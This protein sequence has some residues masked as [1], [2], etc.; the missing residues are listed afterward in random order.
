[1]ANHNGQGKPV[2]KHPPKAAAEL[3]EHAVLDQRDRLGRK[4]PCANALPDGCRRPL[5][6]P[7]QNHTACCLFFPY[8]KEFEGPA[9][10][11]FLPTLHHKVDREDEQSVTLPSL[12]AEGTLTEQITQLS[13]P[14]L[15]SL[16]THI[17]TT[18]TLPGMVLCPVQHLL[19]KDRWLGAEAL[20]EDPTRQ[21]EPC[22]RTT[23]TATYFKRQ[24]PP[25]ASC[26]TKG[27]AGAAG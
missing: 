4:K 17:M 27:K 8:T 13:S 11:S 21:Q 2:G 7:Q 20:Q 12:T 6:F 26:C 18:A 19:A 10:S 1:M 25:N 23:S 16:P 14:G 24:T 15:P 22:C 9:S 5:T 3:L